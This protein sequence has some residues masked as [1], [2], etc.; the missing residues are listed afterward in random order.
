MSNVFAE[1]RETQVIGGG[2]GG[3]GGGFGGSWCI[4]IVFF[5]IAW[6]LFKDGHNDH[7]HGDHGYGPG[8]GYGYGGCGPC[9]QPT[10]KDES[11]FEEERNINAKLC[12][13]DKDIWETDRD[14]WKTACET[15]K[16]IACDGQKT[17][18][19]I[20]QN[21]IQDLR[22]KLAEKNDLV[23]TLKQE[24]F[25]EKKFD[26]LAALIGCTNSK[27]EKLE[28]E[29]PKRAPVWCEGITPDTHHTD[30]DHRRDFD[31]PR[32]G[33]CDNWDGCCA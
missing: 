11:N 21:Y 18:A 9:V 25:T 31:F 29:I 20:E 1:D 14:V 24:M 33:R 6:L 23:M 15:Q 12:C 27:I 7:G 4:I 8:Y 28:C 22:D 16:E 26:Q 17:R 32:R 10:F 19:L 2:Y 5:V 13:I 3:Y 30:C